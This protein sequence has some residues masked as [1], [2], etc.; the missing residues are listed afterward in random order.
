MAAT[1]WPSRSWA[2]ACLVGMVGIGD[3]VM[4]V[5]ELTDRGAR[6]ALTLGLGSG[7]L[8]SVA[9]IALSGPIEYCASDPWH[10][11]DAAD[12]R[13][14]A[15]YDRCGRG[16]L[17]TA[18]ARAALPGRLPYRS[19][20]LTHRFCCRGAATI[21][22]MGA[23]G[24]ALGQV[25]RGAVAM[26]VGLVWA[27]RFAAAGLRPGHGAGVHRLLRTSGQPE[28]GALRDRQPAAVVR[29]PPGRWQGHWGCFPAATRSCRSPPTS[30][31]SG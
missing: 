3:S 24:L 18:A 25:A 6:T 29:C 15:A 13:R 7:V 19:H 30:S 9:L 17:W 16:L 22:G 12:P 5:P 20:V 31:A 27:A 8:L 1:P 4:R 11:A 28:P 23:A 26:L 14:A 2:L 21:S 10:G